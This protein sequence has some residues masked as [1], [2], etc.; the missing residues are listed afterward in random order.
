MS[1]MR[2]CHVVAALP[3]ARLPEKK[4]GDLLVAADAGYLQLKKIGVSPDAVIGDFDSAPRPSGDGVSVFPKRKDDTDTLLALREGLARGYREFRI[5]GAIG[6]LLDHTLANIQA[7]VF[8]AE[9]GARG[10]L[11]GDRECASLLRAGDRLTLPSP[12]TGARLS[13]FA[14]SESAA[15]SLYGLAYSGE[16]ILLSSAFPLG[17]GNLFTEE[18]AQ[19][20]VTKG[21][22]LL[23]TEALL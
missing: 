15:V 6:G 9:N 20:S 23:V 8:L 13:L 12:K 7:L 11:V 16:D 19:I 14:Y 3:T 1:N 5:Y 2:I 18:D 21:T 4:N 10:V 17:V 22:V